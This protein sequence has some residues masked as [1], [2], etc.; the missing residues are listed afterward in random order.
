MK[1]TMSSL[2]SVVLVLGLV[3]LISGAR[4]KASPRRKPSNL[5]ANCFKCSP[6]QLDS[7]CIKPQLV[8]DFRRDCPGGEDEVEEICHRS[9]F[10]STYSVSIDDP[11]LIHDSD[12][13]P[14]PLPG[15]NTFYALDRFTG[16]PGSHITF[17]F[18]DVAFSAETKRSR[19]SYI[20]VGSG[21]DPTMVSAQ[22]ARISLDTPA[23]TDGYTVSSNE[24][25]L[26]VVHPKGENIGFTVRVNVVSESPAIV[27][28]VGNDADVD[29]GMSACFPCLSS[30]LIC[31]SW[32]WHCDGANDCDE[33]EDEIGCPCMGFECSDGK[34]IE[35]GFQCDG[36][37]DCSND[38]TDCPA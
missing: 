27:P 34:C 10:T 19:R 13:A 9:R 23:S 30:D 6:G 28:A 3:A 25:W 21:D 26:L 22:V 20:A 4:P 14:A 24:A 29:V 38:E 11:I 17:E 1:I 31:V 12:N 18:T 36:I 8:C 7:P 32:D 35:K 16:P 33:G 2:F 5:K 15:T 37:V